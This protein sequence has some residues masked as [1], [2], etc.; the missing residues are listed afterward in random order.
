MVFVAGVP[1]FTLSGRLADRVAYIPLLLAIV[2]SFG[3][4]LLVLTVATG[5]VQLVGVSIV[6]GL[7]IHSVFPAAD[8]YVLDSLPDVH[9]A[10][11]YAVFSATIIFMNSLGSVV[12]GAL[13]DAGFAHS[14]VFRAFGVGVVAF[15]VVLAFVH[16][17]IGFPT[18][19]R[20][21]DH[22]KAS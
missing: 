22:S 18:G 17:T 20:L 6:L 19:R 21:P 8:T 1:A 3:V 13:L 2:G 14:T 10:S 16:R 15:V 9:R 11:A 5:V 12:V 4:C 7:I